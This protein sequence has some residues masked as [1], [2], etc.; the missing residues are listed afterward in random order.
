M[1]V[2]QPPYENVD[3]A[4][5]VVLTSNDDEPV[6]FSVLRAATDM[7]A[8]LKDMLADQATG[9]EVVIPCSNVPA[10]ALKYV[11]QYIEHHYNNKAEPFEKPLK[12]KIEEVISE[13]DKTFLY[14]DLVK[15]GK[16]EEHDLLVEV[17]FAANFLSIKDLIELGC[18][19]A[20][21]MIKGKTPE[22]IRALF[23]IENDF[24]PEQEEKIKQQNRECL[25]E[26]TN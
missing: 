3:W 14:T 21:S 23:Q 13:W 2:V 12:G 11:I 25:E 10:R 7:S 24:T 9:E 20:A 4:T 5:H 19:C 8:L 6:H 15:N 22:Q 17:I 16:E 1:S 18:G 26:N